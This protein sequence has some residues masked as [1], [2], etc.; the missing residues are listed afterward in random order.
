MLKIKVFAHHPLS[1][2]QPCPRC[3]RQVSCLQTLNL[4]K[5]VIFWNKSAGST[6]HCSRACCRRRTAWGSRCSRA[7]RRLAP[8]TARN[9]AKAAR[10]VSRLARPNAESCLLR[11]SMSGVSRLA[12]PHAWMRHTITMW[13]EGTC[14]KSIWTSIKQLVGV[15]STWPASVPLPRV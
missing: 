9:E 1:G 11:P 14:M 2:Q 7:G 13:K 6:S 5:R 10:T 3:S 4:N 12:E 8:S 15:S